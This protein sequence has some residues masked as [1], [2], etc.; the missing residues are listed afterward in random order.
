MP[1][2]T[3]RPN[4]EKFR[5]APGSIQE[6]DGN[7]GRMRGW[8]AT[9]SEPHLL[10]EPVGLRPVRVSDARMWREIRVRNAPWLR[11]WEPTNPETPLYRSSLGPYF[12]MARAIRREARLGQAVPWV[13]TFN[14]VFVGQLTIGS[15]TWGSARSGQVGYWIDEADARRGL[16]ATTLPRAGRPRLR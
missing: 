1:G 10:G 4:P 6:N 13:V 14:G 9:L 12:A 5:V 8:P 11:P 16:I 7:V 15:I 3:L 2:R